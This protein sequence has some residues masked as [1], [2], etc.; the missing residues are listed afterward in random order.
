MDKIYLYIWIKCKQVYIASG[1]KKIIT[2][3]F[4]LKKIFTVEISIF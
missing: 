4:N 2:K 3:F 1:K